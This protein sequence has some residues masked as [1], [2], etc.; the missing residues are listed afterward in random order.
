MVPSLQLHLHFTRRGRANPNGSRR[1]ASTDAD[2]NALQVTAG[3]ADP[4]TSLGMRVGSADSLTERTETASGSE[5]L[6]EAVRGLVIRDYAARRT[7]S[8]SVAG[9]AVSPPMRFA[10]TASIE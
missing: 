10:S 8:G 2:P 6:P 5:T 7:R 4:S 3:R 9:V 1:T